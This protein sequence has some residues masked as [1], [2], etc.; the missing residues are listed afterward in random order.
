MQSLSIFSCP[1]C[2]RLMETFVPLINNYTEEQTKGFLKGFNYD[3][4]FDYGKKH[5]KER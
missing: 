3:Y 2:N 4:I 1:L 5:I